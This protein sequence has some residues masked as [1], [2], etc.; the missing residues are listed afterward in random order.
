MSLPCAHNSLTLRRV[1][2]SVYNDLVDLTIMPKDVLDRLVAWRMDDPRYVSSNE[3]VKGRHMLRQ[4]TI[5]AR[6][7]FADKS[8]ND[9]IDRAIR[10]AAVHVHATL[11]LLSDGQKPLVVCFS[12]D[13]MDGHQEIALYRDTL[14]DAVAAHGDKMDGSGVTDE[15]LAAAAEMQ[16]EKSGS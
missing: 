10:E 3:R 12:D 9:A 7:D 2:G 16:H 1:R 8:K 4:W 15:L 13:F 5:E 14:G 11:A 6:A